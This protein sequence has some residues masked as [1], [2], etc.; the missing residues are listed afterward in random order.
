MLQTSGST[1]ALNSTL[2]F[3][4]AMHSLRAFMMFK[5]IASLRGYKHLLVRN[6]LDVMHSEHRKRRNSIPGI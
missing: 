2:S 5:I 1:I 3:N 6:Y 4:S